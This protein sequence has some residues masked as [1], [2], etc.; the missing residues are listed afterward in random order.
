MRGAR[1]RRNEH[2]LSGHDKPLLRWLK[3]GARGYQHQALPTREQRI[4]HQTSDC[5]FA[6]DLNVVTSSATDLTI[7][8]QKVTQYAQWGHLTI[9]MEKSTVTAA[10]HQQCPQTPYDK[11]TI[12]RRLQA[13]VA[14][15]GRPVQ[16]QDP[17][18]AFRYL[19]VHMTMDLNW[20]P[21]LKATLD[22]L[23]E[24]TSRL[25]GSWLTYKQQLHILKTCIRPMVAYP[26]IG[27]PY[28][29][30]HIK[31]LDSMLC[32]ATKRAL[33]LGIS[34]PNAVVHQPTQD[35]HRHPTGTDAGSGQEGTGR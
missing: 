33:K 21:Q 31:Q 29:P 28:E 30:H 15:Q 22:K 27:A 19:G 17:K 18:Q 16:V 10:L 8:A 13:A 11:Q 12:T 26:F 34:T 2:A 6:D 24:K 23:R 32:T 5:T 4:Q 1:A 20:A 9:N 25:N 7:Q 14:I 3:V 35:T